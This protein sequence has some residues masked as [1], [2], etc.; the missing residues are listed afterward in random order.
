MR[1]NNTTLQTPDHTV[2]AKQH[3]ENFP[4]ASIVLPKHL[5]YPI[6]LIY[7][8]ARCADDFADE[9]NLTQTERLTLL[10]EYVNELDIIQKNG[11]SHSAFFTELAQ[12][13]D[14]KKLP[15]APFYDLLDAFKQDVSKVRYANFD[16][17]LDYC[18]RSANPIGLLLLHLFNKASI[19]NIAYSDHVCSALQLINFYQDIAIDYDTQ[20]HQGRLYLCEDEMAHFGV[21]EQQIA[22]KQINENWI[23]LMQ[24]NV[25]RAE[26]MLK[27]GKPLGNIL[28]GRI[29]LEMRLIIAGGETIIEKLKK[30]NGDIFNHRPII[31]AWDWPSI[32]L[33]AIF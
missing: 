24:F 17:V 15:L 9:G 20:F 7:H 32:L 3:Y 1:M 31:S 8:F 16:E 33:K 22:N 12:M 5:R 29:G 30:V 23:K 13:I 26:I 4:V 18:R 19:Q 27:K 6:T 14:D 11:N 25:E 2:L 10:Q 28:P 21:T